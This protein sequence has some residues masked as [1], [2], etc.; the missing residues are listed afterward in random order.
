M[1]VVLKWEIATEVDNAGFNIWKSNGKD[2][3]YVK[4][5]ELLIPGEGG[6]NWGSDYSFIDKN[7]VPGATY[8]YKLEDVEFDE[9]STLHGP[10]SATV[11]DNREKIERLRR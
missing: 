6:G 4:V 7:V 3:E 11:D 8:L 10:V 5:N 2:E 1:N 9:E